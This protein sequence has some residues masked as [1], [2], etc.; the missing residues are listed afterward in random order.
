M[1]K[2]ILLLLATALTGNVFG[3]TEEMEKEYLNGLVK[4]GKVSQIEAR[5]LARA[6]NQLLTDFNGYP[7]LP[8]NNESMQVE[9]I[10]VKSFP[11]IRKTELMNYLEEWV[12]IQYGSIRE[13]LHYK[14]EE[15]GKL[16]VKGFFEMEHEDVVKNFWGNPKETVITAKCFHTIIFT[17]KDEKLKIEYTTIKFESE[18]GGYVAGNTYIPLTTT[19]RY[20][21]TLYPV[22]S[23]DQITWKSK[24]S[25]LQ[26]VSSQVG[27]RS[28]IIELYI[29]SRKEYSG[30]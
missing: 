4:S 26:E 28:I 21:H 24:L 7:E 16:I 19:E 14:N 2:A 17:I 23:G 22:T 13:V 15:T 29:K 18:Y 1:K 25:T 3:Q 5:E 12:A 6:W 20:L 11:G 27:L 30:F 10:F 8:Y 9:F